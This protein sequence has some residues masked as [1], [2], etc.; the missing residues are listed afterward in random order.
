MYVT[1]SWKVVF[2][3]DILEDIHEFMIFMH[4]S[5]NRI[6]VSNP[7]GGEEMIKKIVRIFWEK[8][9]N[10]DYNFLTWKVKD[11]ILTNFIPLVSSYTPWKH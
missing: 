3:L 2:S 1:R 8:P 10:E 6:N 5:Y 11:I 4:N 7:E 9:F